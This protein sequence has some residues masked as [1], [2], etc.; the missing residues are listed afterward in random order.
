MSDDRFDRAPDD[1]EDAPEPDA[2]R[3]RMVA[4]ITLILTPQGWVVEEYPIAVL[5]RDDEIFCTE[6]G[7]VLSPSDRDRCAVEKERARGL[8]LPSAQ[9]VADAFGRAAQR[10]WVPGH[11]RSN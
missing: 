3:I 5:D 6:E 8:P 9:A 10:G 7:H 4:A 1:L 11:A 2:H